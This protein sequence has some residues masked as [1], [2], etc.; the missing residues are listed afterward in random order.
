MNKFFLVLIG[1]VFSTTTQAQKLKLEEIMKGEAF[2][3]S[4]PDTTRWSLDGKKVYFEWNP[5]N[6]L[7]SSTYFWEKGQ[8]KPKLATPEERAFSKLDFLA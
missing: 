8:A 1:I 6:E 5:N 3:G 7:G 2:I 4:Q